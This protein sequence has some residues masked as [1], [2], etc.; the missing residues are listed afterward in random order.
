LGI[1]IF[2]FDEVVNNGKQK[3]QPYAKV[4]RDDIFTFSYTSGTTGTGKACMLSHGNMV[5][6][7]AVV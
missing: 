6:G 2:T 7:V 5:S 4:T 1:K 3:K